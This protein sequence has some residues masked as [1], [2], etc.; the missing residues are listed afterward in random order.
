MKTKATNAAQQLKDTPVDTV[1]YT[2]TYVP[3]SKVV[4]VTTQQQVKNYLELPNAPL[5]SQ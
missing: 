1:V 4:L 5:S 2:C 3:L